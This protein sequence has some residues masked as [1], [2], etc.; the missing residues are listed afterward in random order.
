MCVQADTDLAM[1]MLESSSNASEAASRLDSIRINAEA[2]KLASLPKPY[3]PISLCI[4]WA[5]RYNTG[6]LITLTPKGLVFSFLF[7]HSAFQACILAAYE[8]RAS[9]PVNRQAS[10]ASRSDVFS[11]LSHA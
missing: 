1:V 6:L 7:S 5:A 4:P 10:R 8:Y 11:V 2:S 9:C 3:T